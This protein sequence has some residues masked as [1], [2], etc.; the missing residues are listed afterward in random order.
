[1]IICT[2]TF[3]VA[4]FVLSLH[5]YK[6]TLASIYLCLNFCFHRRNDLPSLKLLI[7]SL[8]LDFAFIMLIL[9]SVIIIIIIII[10]NHCDPC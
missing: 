7:P 8:C 9:M 6:S 4:N 3:L 2:V 1:M 10:V 5:H